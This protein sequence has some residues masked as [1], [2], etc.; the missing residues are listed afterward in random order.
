[1]RRGLRFLSGLFATLITTSEPMAT[2]TRAIAPFMVTILNCQDIR[3]HYANHTGQVDTLHLC[4]SW[5][6]T[7]HKSS[8]RCFEGSS[9]VNPHLN[10][11][12]AVPGFVLQCLQ[13]P[14]DS[15]KQNK[16]TARVRRNGPINPMQSY[17][18]CSFTAQTKNNNCLPP[19]RKLCA[20]SRL[21]ITTLLFTFGLATLQYLWL[22]LACFALWALLLLVAQIC[23][24]GVPSCRG[25]KIV[26]PRKQDRER[27]RERERETDGQ[28]QA[29]VLEVP[30][31]QRSRRLQQG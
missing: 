11:F 18:F 12:C 6:S 23:Q 9:W 16:T 28:T 22:R 15:A 20:G 21:I 26:L 17:N 29:D 10:K 25:S 8:D 30:L 27:D 1:M 2:I 5:P 19:Y 24:I 7:D 4:S 13:F 14:S 31:V 3:D